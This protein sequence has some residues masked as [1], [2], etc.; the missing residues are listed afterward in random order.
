MDG[1]GCDMLNNLDPEDPMKF[2]PVQY[3]LAPLLQFENVENIGNVVLSDWTR[4]G[5]TNIGNSGREFMV[6]QVFNSKT[7]LQHATKLYSISVHQEYVVSS[8]KKLL[9]LRCKKIEQSQCPW[10]LHAMVV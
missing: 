4:W 3:H 10:K 2:S 7:D 8:T 9:V 6:S 5:N 1:E